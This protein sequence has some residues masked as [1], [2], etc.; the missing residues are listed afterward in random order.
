MGFDGFV[1][2]EKWSLMVVTAPG[3][4]P[5]YPPWNA[6]K[7]WIPAWIPADLVSA[8]DLSKL[9]ILPARKPDKT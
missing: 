9:N 6:L 1:T 4:Q 3:H 5:G 2:S 8:S 7:P